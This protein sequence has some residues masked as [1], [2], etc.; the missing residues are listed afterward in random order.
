MRPRELFARLVE[1][2]PSPW[3]QLP[4]AVLGETREYEQVLV[5]P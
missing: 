3:N 5:E 4:L 2:R 1:G